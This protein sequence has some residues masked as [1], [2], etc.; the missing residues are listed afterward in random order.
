AAIKAGVIPENKRDMAEDK[1]TVDIYA[2]SGGGLSASQSMTLD[3]VASSIAQGWKRPVYF[4]STVP[5]SL[6]MGLRPYM[7]STGLCYQV[8][9]I[10]CN[11]ADEEIECNTDKMY[12]IVTTKYKWGGLDKAKPGS[13]YLDE[14][15][16]R[17]VTTMR[18]SMISLASSL[19]IEGI[20][21]LDSLGIEAND[22]TNM[23]AFAADRFKKAE[24]I[25]D[26]MSEKMPVETAP[27]QHTT[28]LQ[29]ADC[30]AKI[31]LYGNKSETAKKKAIDVLEKEAKRYAQFLIFYESTDDEDIDSGNFMR[32][33]LYMVKAASQLFNLYRSVN[34]E[35]FNNFV[36]KF[37]SYEKSGRHVSEETMKLLTM[38]EEERQRIAYEQAR[39]EAEA[40]Q[41]AQASGMASGEAILP[42]QEG[43]GESF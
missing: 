20:K 21:S 29:I 38:S 39:A 41:A 30:Y 25:L 22:T 40:Q 2:A 8:T 28:A 43:F 4:A 1:I 12:E 33:D 13:L 10:K 31:Y 9:P 32:Y 42:K 7:L 6:Y 3:L 17:M 18:N 37:K 24:H 5:E 15:V 19:Y 26:L 34:P 11:D 16:M 36:K 23:P 14:T 35:N 27:Y